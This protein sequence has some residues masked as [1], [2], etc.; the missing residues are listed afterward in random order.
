MI[1]YLHFLILRIHFKMM[2][3]ILYGFPLPFQNEKKKR[4]KIRSQSV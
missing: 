2:F 1:N 3:D 4:R